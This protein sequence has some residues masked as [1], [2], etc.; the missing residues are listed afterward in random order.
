MDWKELT[1]WYDEVEK[2]AARIDEGKVGRE[3]T[4]RCAGTQDARLIGLFAELRVALETGKQV[5]ATVYRGGDGGFDFTNNG[6]TWDVKGA[7][8]WTDPELKI[9]VKFELNKPIDYFILVA[10][11][12]DTQRR[13]CWGRI[14]GYATPDQIRLHGEE[15]DYGYGPRLVLKHGQ[16]T[17]G[18]PI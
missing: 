17:G 1:P 4:N 5:D 16:L 14:M 6:R 9:N 18:L 2:A 8:F 12:L 3:H 11:N 7:T 10:L 13:T 15:H